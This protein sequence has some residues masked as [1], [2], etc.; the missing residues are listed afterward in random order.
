MARRV[1]HRRGAHLSAQPSPTLAR[2]E[3][4]KRIIDCPDDHQSSSA[5]CISSSSNFASSRSFPLARVA[6]SRR[7]GSAVEAPARPPLRARRGASRPVRLD[8]R[9][10]RRL[11]FAP[12][13]CRDVPRFAS[14]RREDGPRARGRARPRGSPVRNRGRSPCRTPPSSA[15]RRR[16]RSR[17]G[18]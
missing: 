6:T 16:G 2:L 9:P 4:S 3:S 17:S 18:G 7:I 8:P 10:R 5:G 13:A 1:V 14:P 11:L 15:I 12:D